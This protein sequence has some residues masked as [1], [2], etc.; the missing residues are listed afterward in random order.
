MSQLSFFDL[1]ADPKGNPDGPRLWWSLQYKPFYERAVT[2]FVDLYGVAPIFHLAWPGRQVFLTEPSRAMIIEV[3]TG[4]LNESGRG[5]L[6]ELD[7]RGVKAFRPQDV[8][9]QIVAVLDGSMPR[10]TWRPMIMAEVTVPSFRA[11]TL[12]TRIAAQG[13]FAQQWPASRDTMAFRVFGDPAVLAS[14]PY[15]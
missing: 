11:E 13:L 6:W 2:E 5:R 10:E 7:Y 14:L 15:A 8:A 1:C 9:P 3:A 12:A 4:V